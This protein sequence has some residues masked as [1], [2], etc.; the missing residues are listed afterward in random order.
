MTDPV[1]FFS[2]AFARFDLRESLE[3]LCCD[4]LQF[5]WE[6]SLLSP[7]DEWYDAYPSTEGNVFH[8]RCLLGF[9]VVRGFMGLKRDQILYRC[10]FCDTELIEPLGFISDGPCLTLRPTRMAKG[11]PAFEIPKARLRR[12]LAETKRR[13]RG[14]WPPKD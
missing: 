12:Y 9:R 7:R 10:P 6:N 11:R 5:M 3:E 13:N 1:N 8:A 2:E 14:G 4:P